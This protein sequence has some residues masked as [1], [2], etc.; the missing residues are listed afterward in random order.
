[1]LVEAGDQEALAQAILK[2]AEDEEYRKN[3]SEN[4]HRLI[5]E[6]FSLGN[7]VRALQ[8]YYEEVLS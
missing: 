6:K 8:A 3:L 1:V 4:A 7:G 2:F 5:Y